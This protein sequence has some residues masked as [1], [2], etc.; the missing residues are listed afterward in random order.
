MARKKGKH[1]TI[2]YRKSLAV[3]STFGQRLERKILSIGYIAKCNGRSKANARK[4]FALCHGFEKMDGRSREKLEKLSNPKLNK[5]IEEYIGLCEPSKVLVF[6][7]SK[8]DIEFIRKEAIRK[9]E[10]KMLAIKGHTLHFDSFHDQGRDKK[11]TRILVPKGVNLGHGIETMDREEGLKGIREV[12]GGMMN[13]KEM[14]VLFYCLGPLDSE[15]SIPCVQITDSAYVAHNENLLFRQGYREFLKEGNKSR[16]F[17]F[18]HSQ[19]ELDERGACKNI[20]KRRVYIDLEDKTVFSA[21]TQYG[22]NSI[23]LKKLAMRLSLQKASK[24]GWLLEHMFIMGV[25]GP[26]GR[27]SYVLG[28]FPSLCGKTSTVMMEGEEIMG[29]D[30]AFIRKRNG[31][32]YAVNVEKGMFGIIQGVN[33]KDDAML[34]KSLHKET[35]VIFSNVLVTE[36]GKIHWIGKDGETPLKGWNHSGEWF[37]GKKIED[38][39]ILSSHPNARFTIGLESCSNA[40]S[41]LNDPE[42]VGVGAIVYGGRDSDTCVPVEQGFD[43][44]HGMITKGACLESETTAA[45]LGKE[46]VREFNPMSNLDF[47]SITIGEY[48]GLNLEF[49]KDVSIPIFSVNYFLKNKEGKLLT[50]RKDKKIWYKWIDLRI[51]GEAD[52]IKTPMGLIPKYE[53]LKRLFKQVLGKDYSKEQ[54]GEQFKIRL[55]ENIAKIDRVMLIY[56]H[57]IPD[58]PKRLFEVLEEQKKSLENARKEYGDYISPFDLG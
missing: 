24:E 21:N 9:N 30:I 11:N 40:S 33:S 38:K 36:E 8:E 3:A 2:A 37:K 26:K 55:L 52:A 4:T 10:E 39:E 14:Y 50:E 58:T 31:K 5:F 44:E 48:V 6:G 22:G 45:T 47:L 27:T 34:W 23:G 53:D 29:D 28:A 12:M 49:G 43:W 1:K 54:Y 15:F 42:G 56:K 17:K 18:V 35:E 13:G 41:K 51:N 57:N 20:D 25:K 19:G 46:G 32:A 16:F 7:D